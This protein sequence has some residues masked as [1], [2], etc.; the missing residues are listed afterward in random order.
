MAETTITVQNCV[1]AG[2]NV[3]LAAANTDGSKFLN[4]T[5]ERTFL[6]VENANAATRNVVIETQQ[7]S[8]PVSGYGAVALADTTVTVPANTGKTLIGPFPAGQ[9][10][11]ADGYCHITF[12]AVTNLTI[13]AVRMAR[14]A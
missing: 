11:D 10:N 2:L 3:T 8:V 1:L 13:A 14:A 12:S 9:F 5:D 6:L 7:T 4:P